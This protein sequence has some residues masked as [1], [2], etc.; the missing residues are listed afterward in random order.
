MIVKAGQNIKLSSIPFHLWTTFW[1][2]EERK[3]SKQKT[4]TYFHWFYVLL[5]EE[6][7]L[8]M[9]KASAGNSAVEELGQTRYHQIENRLEGTQNSAQPRTHCYSNL[10]RGGTRS[11]NDPSGVCMSSERRVYAHVRMESLQ[12]ECEG[13]AITTFIPRHPDDGEQCCTDPEYGCTQT[14]T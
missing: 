9:E 6:K 13:R 4:T 11:T 5:I 7:P 3:Q 2:P 1:S 8:K 14:R 10:Q 12:Q